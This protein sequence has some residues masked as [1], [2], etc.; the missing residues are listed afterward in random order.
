MIPVPAHPGSLAL[1]RLLAGDADALTKAHA[2]SCEVCRGAL[3]AFKAE[4]IAFE[5][6]VPFD[7]FAA[8]VERKAT[9]QRAG[10]AAPRRWWSDNVRLA[11]GL[12]ACFV[13]VVVAQRVVPGTPLARTKGAADVELVVAAGPAGTQRVAS[14]DPRAPEVLTHG[15]RVRVGV[16]PAAWHFVLVISI[17]ATGAV[18]PIYAD[19]ARSLPL[20]GTSPEFLP[21]SLEFT[22]SGLEHVVVLL[23]DRA[24]DVDVVGHSLREQ[25]AAANGDL[26]TIGALAVP[27]EQFHRTFQKP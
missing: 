5:R 22:G 19:G 25:F 3:D 16:T 11:V 15:E 1:R 8:A 26:T 6:E 27:G 13:A 17:D 24:L 12:A 14:P 23:S 4:Q 10:A 9:Q 2:A 18:T 21:D 7:R 20:S